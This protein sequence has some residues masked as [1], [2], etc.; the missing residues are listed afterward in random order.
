MGRKKKWRTVKPPAGG[1]LLG[2]LGGAAEPE[3]EYPLVGPHESDQLERRAIESGWPEPPDDIKEAIIKRQSYIAASPDIDP[4][5]NVKAFRAMT[6]AYTPKQPPPN[7]TVNAQVNVGPQ[8]VDTVLDRKRQ[9]EV[10]LAEMNLEKKRG[11]LLRRD[12]VEAVW[13]VVFNRIQS[14]MNQISRISQDAADILKKC[15]D[16][17]VEDLSAIQPDDQ[18][19]R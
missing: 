6:E 5:V 12:E 15:L 7:Q 18:L 4:A 14:A 17:S 9:A 10:E 13:D 8:R 1:K 2:G 3:E 19:Q 16:E 11:E